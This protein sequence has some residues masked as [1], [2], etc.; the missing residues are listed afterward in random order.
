LELEARCDEGNL[1]VVGPPPKR[2]ILAGLFV[3]PAD[4]AAV[5]LTR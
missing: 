2:L 3:Q 5:L 4:T 1:H